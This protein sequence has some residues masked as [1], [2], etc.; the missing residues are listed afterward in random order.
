M[1]TKSFLF[2]NY[3]LNYYESKGDV[4]CVIV[5]LSPCIER[6]NFKNGILILKLFANSYKLELGFS[7]KFKTC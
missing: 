6:P 4:K 7:F 2:N 3:T 1:C 5:L